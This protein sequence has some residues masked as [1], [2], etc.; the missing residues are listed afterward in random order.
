MPATYLDAAIQAYIEEYPTVDERGIDPYWWN[1]A[2]TPPTKTMNTGWIPTYDL[3]AAAADIWEQKAATLSASVDT[4][5]PAG[6]KTNSQLYEQAMKLARFHKS[7]RN[8]RTIAQ[9]MK[10]DIHLTSEV[11]GNLAEQDETWGD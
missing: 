11:I 8:P 4:S 9:R 7:Q 10:P 2:T 3:H 5:S 6:A 1:S